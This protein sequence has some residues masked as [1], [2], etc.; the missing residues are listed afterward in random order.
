MKLRLLK[1][2]CLTIL[3][4]IIVEGGPVRAGDLEQA[5]GAFQGGNTQQAAEFYGKITPDDPEWSDKLEDSIRWFFINKKYQSAWRVTQL[6]LRT[7][8]QIK[9]LSYYEKLSALK[10]GACPLGSRVAPLSFEL[11]AQ[12]HAVRFYQRLANEPTA[13]KSA[14]E[15]ADRGMQVSALADFATPYLR[16]LKNT[17]LIS[18]MGCRFNRPKFANTQMAEERELDLLR[19]YMARVTAYPEERPG[20]D[21]PI[22]IRIMELARKLKYGDLSKA[23]LTMFSRVSIEDWARLKDPERRYL[24]NVLQEEGLVPARMLVVGSREDTIVKNIL[25]TTEAVDAA[26][27]LGIVNF[28]EWPIKDREVLFAFLDQLIDLPYHDEII[29]RRAILSYEAGA[30]QQTVEYLRRI[31]ATPEASEVSRQGALTIVERLLSE[32]QYNEGMLG[33][34]QGAVPVAYW[35][36]VYRGILIDHALR[37]NLQ[38]FLAIENQLMSKNKSSNSMSRLPPDLLAIYE[39]LAH[40]KSLE[41][42]KMVE[43]LRERRPNEF[44]IYANDIATRAEGL[45]DEEFE[46]IEAVIAQLVKLLRKDLDSGKAQ[47]QVSSLLASLERSSHDQRSLAEKAARGGVT[48]IGA[49]NIRPLVKLQNPFAWTQGVTTSRRDFLVVPAQVGDRAWRIE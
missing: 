40:R 27:W 9:D 25:P 45:S 7:H 35:P 6:A 16:D 43:S 19:L 14:S 36:R 12:A 37:G 11:L 26:S 34:I 4:S 24:W 44:M 1:F 42:A 30:H 17:K 22:Q 38:G 15:A 29:L 48:H 8:I 20:D 41:Y 47:T 2:G 28:D 18:G 39:A 5:R 13:P 33:A 32:Y 21:R 46:K 3:V 23:I 31:L 10:F 49:V